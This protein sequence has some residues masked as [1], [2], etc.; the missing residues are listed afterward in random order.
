[1]QL[2]SQKPTCANVGMPWFVRRSYFLR[3]LPA[4]ECRRSRGRGG[5]SRSSLSDPSLPCN[6]GGC[7]RRLI[8]AMHSSQPSF[9][10]L[11]PAVICSADATRDRRFLRTVF[12]LFSPRV[13][14]TTR[15][16][17]ATPAS[18]DLKACTCKRAMEALRSLANAVSPKRKRASASSVSPSDDELLHTMIPLHWGFSID[19]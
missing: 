3:K 13:A 14:L 2:P 12:F 11:I 4:E 8:S 15:L 19:K 18:S 5:R 9:S 6:G 1:M 16:G 10:M 7:P 17:L